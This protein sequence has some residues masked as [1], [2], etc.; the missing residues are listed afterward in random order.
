MLSNHKL[1]NQAVF[2]DSGAKT[3][4]EVEYDGFDFETP[5]SLLNLPV[6]VEMDEVIFENIF[7]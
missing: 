6:K 5:Q 1:W 3:E 2:A 4:P 7:M